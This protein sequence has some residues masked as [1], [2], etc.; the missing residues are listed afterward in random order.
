VTFSEESTMI[1]L[2]WSRMY[3]FP[4]CFHVEFSIEDFQSLDNDRGVEKKR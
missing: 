4:L 2:S 1:L 3:D